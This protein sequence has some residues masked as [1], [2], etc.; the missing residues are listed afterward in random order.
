MSRSR[1]PL[2]DHERASRTRH[3]ARRQVLAM[4]PRTAFDA[5]CT[6]SLTSLTISKLHF[7]V[8]ASEFIHSGPRSARRRARMSRCRRVAVN[9]GPRRFDFAVWS[10]WQV[11]SDGAR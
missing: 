11:C 6:P 2:G 8:S 9:R 4:M 3:E 7:V 1:R 5:G 10:H